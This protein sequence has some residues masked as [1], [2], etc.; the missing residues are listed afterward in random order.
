MCFLQ[1]YL[2][3]KPKKCI[4]TFYHVSLFISLLHLLG[5]GNLSLRQILRLS[6]L[7]DAFPHAAESTLAGRIDDMLMVPYLPP[8]KKEVVREIMTMVGIDCTDEV[9][10]ES[11]DIEKDIQGT[12]KK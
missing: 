7:S 12:F 8:T 9:G 5:M 6:R 10:N 2:S 11:N 3:N 1:L 4:L